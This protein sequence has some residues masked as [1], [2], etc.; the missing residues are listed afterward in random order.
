M[1]EASQLKSQMEAIRSDRTI[2]N[3]PDPIPPLLNQITAL[4]RKGVSEIHEL[5]VTERDREVAELEA[6]ENW[7][8][9]QPEERERIL[10]SNGLGPIPEL[11]IGTDQELIDGLED[12]AI[13]AWEERLLALKARVDRARGEAARQV[14]PRA[15]TVRPSPATLNSREDVEAYVRELR[16]R[17]LVQVDEHPVIIP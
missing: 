4:L 8:K 5:M 9:L 12:T 17:L 1:T 16:D 11:C 2:L 7:S 10:V 3:N 6:S 15:V 14:A 13:K